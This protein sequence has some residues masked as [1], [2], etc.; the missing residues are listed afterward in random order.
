ML[1]TQEIRLA[2]DDEHC[3]QS[4]KSEEMEHKIKFMREVKKL[5]DD[6]FEKK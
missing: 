1:R 3:D 2:S 5:Q 6:G 4:S